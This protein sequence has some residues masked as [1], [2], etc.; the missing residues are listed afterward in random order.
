MFNTIPDVRIRDV[1]ARF[2]GIGCECENLAEIGKSYGLTR[3]RIRQIKMQGLRLLCHV[4]R[5]T[6]V[7]DFLA[8]QKNEVTKD[9][10]I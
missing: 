4:S 3:E 8:T 2:Y 9:E 7:E 6:I 10:S 5:R 1:L